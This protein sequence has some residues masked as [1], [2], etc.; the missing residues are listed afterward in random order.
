[1][2]IKLLFFTA[3]TIMLQTTI[4]QT[5]A[6]PD[7]NFEQ[8]LIDL[9]FDTNGLNG[10]ILQS[11]ANAVNALNVNGKNI[12]SLQGIEG[13]V[14]LTT[15]YCNSNTLTSLDVSNNTSLVDLQCGGNQLTSLILGSN[16]NNLQTLICNSNQ[17]TSLDVNNAPALKYL[18][19]Y[20]NQLA[21]LYLNHNSLLK[22][23]FCDNNN[24]TTISIVSN[25]A[26]ERLDCFN[27]QLTTLDLTNNTILEELDCS[28]NQIT[29][30]VV[31]N[32]PALTRLVCH[33]NQIT[34]L[35]VRI[36]T[37][38]TNFRCNNN[39]LTNLNVK[40]GNNTNLTAFSAINNPN[41]TCIEVDDAA[42]STANWTNI[43]AQTSFNESCPTIAIPDVNFELALIQLGY[44]TNGLTGNIL[45]GE[46]EAVTTLDVNNKSIFNLQGIEG[47][48]NL[49][50]LNCY[51]NNLSNLDIS[52]NHILEDL[53][54][55]DNQLNTLIVNNNPALVGLNCRNNSLTALNV[56]SSILLENLNI[57]INNIVSLDLSANTALTFLLVDSNALEVLDVK[58]GNNTNVSF[59]SAAGNPNL[60][61]IQVDNTAF[62][63]TNWTFID[64]QTNFS[65]NCAY[66]NVINIPDPNFEQALIDLG[67][68]TNGLT[69]NILQVEAE[70][71]IILAIANKNISSLQGIEGFVNLESLN[72]EAN[73]LS[74][75]NITNL[76]TLKSLGCH[77]NNIVTL[78]VSQNT[79]LESFNCSTNPLTSLDL[80]NNT[81]LEVLVCNDTQLTSLDLTLNP[82]LTYLLTSSNELTSLNIKNGNNTNISYLNTL[83]NPN[84]TCITAD[85]ILPSWFNDY[86]DGQTSFSEDC[87][88]VILIPDS[89]FEQALLDLGYD[90]N[91]LTGDI[92]KHEAEAVTSLD[93]HSKNIANLQGIEGFI[94]LEELEIR[95]NNIE[96][97]DLSNNTLLVDFFGENNNL[98]ALDLSSNLALKNV[99][100]SINNLSSIDVSTNGALE[101]LFITENQFTSLNVSN[102]IN[103]QV[104]LCSGNQLTSL[105]VSNNSNLIALGCNDNQLTSLDVSNNS[106]LQGLG[107]GDNQLTSLNLKNG[108]NANFLEFSAINNPNLTC[109]EVD[110]AVFSTANWTFIDAH[111]SF[112]EDCAATLGLEE[113]T[114]LD[115]VSLY[116][117]PSSGVFY[118]KGLQETSQIKIYDINGR[119]ILTTSITNNQSVDA[120]NLPKGMYLVSISNPKGQ[121]T[122]KLIIK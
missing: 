57:Y 41:L 75:M 106:N 54:C 48:V 39:Q 79:N 28:N 92:L 15:L 60:T 69:G 51:G 30:L 67:Y 89:N 70:A 102:A 80:D 111:T 121:I 115:T 37:N 7:V 13:F 108:N 9:G 42:Y 61:C 40:N 34:N 29:N 2:K 99:D 16:L 85:A 21:S 55:S 31:N 113:N 87:N 38:L 105:D 72:C 116:P 82:N 50:T 18:Y 20:N 56:S 66:P 120:S 43:D 117:N 118:I 107:C 45:Q 5:I 73:N 84:L 19:C 12:N 122:K 58:N 103:L 94:N 52:N 32:N 4:A 27:N 49:I 93:V 95:N 90:T 26:L 59:F 110:D 112:S 78:D 3:F 97:I 10:N 71:V 74:S 65:G 22:Y 46:A 104:L 33:S 96:T 35:D 14:N 68:D 11:Q 24:L 81:A 36:S 62:S 8:A 25:T 44:D 101:N 119:T 47:F 100:A 91:G 76:N 63:T 83:N 64:A 6:I 1:M 88:Q 86:I 114:L 23:L 77:N 17:L 109:I 53:D 98:I